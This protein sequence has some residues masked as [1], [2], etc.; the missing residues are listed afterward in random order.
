M[1]CLVTAVLLMLMTATGSMRAQA[2]FLQFTT[3][4]RPIAGLPGS[5]S[6][7]PL[8][9]TRDLIRTLSV[10][11]RVPLS[12]LAHEKGFP[13]EQLRLVL[14]VGATPLLD[15]L[16][17]R[18]ATG[19]EWCDVVELQ[20]SRFIASPAGSCECTSAAIAPPHLATDLRRNVTGIWSRGCSR[21]RSE[22]PGGL[23]PLQ[24]P[25]QHLESPIENDSEI[26]GRQRVSQ[27]VLC[28]LQ[29]RPGLGADRHLK[30]VACRSQCP[31]GCN[32]ARL[33]HLPRRWRCDSGSLTAMIRCRGGRRR[34]SRLTDVRFEKGSWFRQLA[35]YRRHVGLR[36][37]GRHD[38]FY[39]ALPSMTDPRQDVEVIRLR[40]EWGHQAKRGQR[41]VTIAE[42]LEQHWK[43]S[44]RA[45]RFDPAIRSV[46][47]EMNDS[48]AVDEQRR[49]PLAEIGSPSVDFGERRDQFDG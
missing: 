28:P 12:P 17:R 47:G 3:G 48:G 37:K 44:S 41:E 1:T 9:A 42:H 29:L 33:G 10:L 22:N 18:L 2:W 5:R 8:E 13:E 32:T 45:R 31:N 26:A 7:L 15:V 46:F 23:L 49:T 14:I 25:H 24:L 20:E 4:I 39:F 38:V 30:S 6:S 27:K 19:G 43:S 21:P 36:S 40:Q 35:K 34:H 16:S 11:D